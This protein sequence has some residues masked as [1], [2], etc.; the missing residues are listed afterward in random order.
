MTGKDLYEVL[1]VARD[2]SPEEIKRVYRRLALQYHPDKNPGDKQ[3]EERFKEITLAYE[4]LSDVEKRTEYDER[5]RR[6]FEAAH[7]GEYD[8]Q[9]IS[10]E[11]ILGRHSDLFSSLFGRGF[12]ARRPAEQRGHD[13][14]SELRI[15]FRTA[16]LGGKVE[17][18][19]GGGKP[20]ADCNGKGTLGA[21]RR[22]SR[23]GGSGR[24]TQRTAEEGQLFSVTSSCPDCG[25]SGLDPGAA[26]DACGGT[27]VVAGERRV[28]VTIPAGSRDDQTLRLRSLGGP[29]FRGGA[30]GDLLLHIRVE[31]DPR[32]R[33]E[34][35]DL[36]VDADVPAPVAVLGG[37]V[38]VPTLNGEATVTVPEGTSAGNKLRLKGE[39]VA[40]GDLL[41]HVRVTV[42]RKPTDEE[43]DLYRRLAE[44]EDRP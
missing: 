4:V 38:S 18:T 32:F 39:G 8:W 22:C 15:D 14:E 3:A 35:N 20:C 37:K 42:P 7:A 27:G 41:V 2:A 6:G 21:E 12:H 10:V 28:T 1:G 5:G 31:P 11:E 26:C 30:P 17:L 13:L 25:G 34:G 43:R 33:R 36:H 9:D 44:L 40:N 24:I 19:L 23:C 16:A 29:G